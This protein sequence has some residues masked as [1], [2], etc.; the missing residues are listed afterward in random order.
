MVSKEL[1]VLPIEFNLGHIFLVKGDKDEALT[2]YKLSFK[3]MVRTKDEKIKTIKEDFKLLS[4][5][6]PEKTEEFKEMEKTLI[7]YVEK[8]GDMKK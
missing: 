3:K 7:D 5:V 1:P 6:Y 8:N 2:K 4:E